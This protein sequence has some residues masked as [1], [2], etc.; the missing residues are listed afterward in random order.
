MIIGEAPQDQQ[1][2]SL[3]ILESTPEIAENMTRNMSH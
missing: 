2:S 1:Y 3:Q